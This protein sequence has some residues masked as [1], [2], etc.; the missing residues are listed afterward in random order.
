MSFDED[1]KLDSDLNYPEK[2]KHILKVCFEHASQLLAAAKTVLDKDNLPNVAYHL[3]TLA[4]EEI[5]K[6]EIIRIR[7]FEIE[8]KKDPIS[9]DKQ[10]EDHVKK[11]YWAIFG[12]FFNQEVITEEKLKQFF[13]LAQHIHDTRIKGLYVDTFEDGVMLPKEKVSKEDAKGLIDLV[14]LTLKQTNKFEIRNIPSDEDTTLIRWFLNASGDQGK[15]KYIACEIS[16]KKLIELQDVNK[17]FAWLKQQFDEADERGKEW[18][19]EEIN[20]TIS[21]DDSDK[22]RF[23]VRLFSNSHTIKQIPLNWFNNL[24]SYVKLYAV[25]KKKNAIDVEYIMP[26]SIHVSHL[27]WTGWGFIRSFVTALNIGSLGYF[28]WYVP[29]Q[30]STYYIKLFDIEKKCEVLVER[31]P[32]LKINWNKDKLTESDL[33][34]ASLCIGMMP[35]PNEKEKHEPFNMYLTGL[36]F[37]SKNDIHFQFEVD[38]YRCFF[39]SLKEGIKIYEPTCVTDSYKDVFKRVLNNIVPQFD[40]VD[41]YYNY[42][43][44]I[45]E[46]KLKKDSITLEQVGMMKA[47]CDIFF[48]T[49]F[50]KMHKE[51]EN[52]SQRKA[53]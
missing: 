33:R 17:W 21:L 46:G 41:K 47:L 27:Y 52:L 16:Q 26:K 5:G 8:Q 48:L 14:E 20:R 34:N 53:H 10:L 23:R 29:E 50:R 40:E 39:Q 32:A 15:R 1:I 24:G 7:P 13:G 12:I 42:S 45:Q 36:M 3:A 38:A 44:E 11:I 4:L 6:A 35:R 31:N 37:L 22:W 43:L 51:N 19:R 9:T 28:W 25:D 18:A 30:V 49:T 2:L